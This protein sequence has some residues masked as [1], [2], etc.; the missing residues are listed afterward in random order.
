MGGPLRIKVKNFTSMR[1][2][3]KEAR[4]LLHCLRDSLKRSERKATCNVGV[5]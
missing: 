3:T 2:R 5:R 1:N 4:E